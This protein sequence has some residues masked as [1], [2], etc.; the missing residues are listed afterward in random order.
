MMEAKKTKNSFSI[1][2]KIMQYLKNHLTEK[3]LISFSFNPLMH[4]VPKWSD[5]LKN[6]AAFAARIL[7]CV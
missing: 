5:I 6:L 1:H 7:K 4:N 2:K 3:L